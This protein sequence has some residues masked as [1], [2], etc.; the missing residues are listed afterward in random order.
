MYIQTRIC[1]EIMYWWMR[2]DLSRHAG[3][4]A[5]DLG[6][7]SMR[8]RRYL[9]T[10]RYIAVEIDEERL[11][12]GSTRHPEAERHLCRIEDFKFPGGG[13]IVICMQVLLNHHFDPRATLDA[14]KNAILLTRRGGCF[15]FTIGHLNR[16]YEE[17]ID[18]L[19]ANAFREVNKL[20]FGKLDIVSPLSLPVGY[21]CGLRRSGWEPKD[22]KRRR[23]YY[24][25]VGRTE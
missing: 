22:S 1:T 2:R 15:I 20:P 19:I 17:E 3:D 14:V 24:H 16:P 5:I 7:G 10:E 25:C 8:H 23:V 6:A 18:R 13:D 4:I 11:N 12:K 9:R 21:L